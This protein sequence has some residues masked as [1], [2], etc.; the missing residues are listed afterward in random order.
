M[1]LD[2]GHQLMQEGHMAGSGGSCY[3]TLK[4][5]ATLSQARDHFWANGCHIH[6]KNRNSIYKKMQ[7]LEKQVWLD[8]NFNLSAARTFIL[9][10]L[11]HA[12]TVTPL[13][14]IFKFCIEFEMTVPVVMQPKIYDFFKVKTLL[15]YC[16]WC[17]KFLKLIVARILWWMS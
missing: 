4:S 8:C 7:S 6:L 17:L 12:K 1:C 11:F 3:A 13:L 15:E 10:G 16:D 5:P 2:G 9:L 14:S